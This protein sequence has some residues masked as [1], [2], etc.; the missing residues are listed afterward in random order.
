MT[1]RILHMGHLFPFCTIIVGNKVVRS[2]REGKSEVYRLI[3]YFEV[4][5]RYQISLFVLTGVYE[6]INLL[7]KRPL[8]VF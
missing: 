3:L 1:L 7:V 6:R 5:V 2:G 4:K 8:I